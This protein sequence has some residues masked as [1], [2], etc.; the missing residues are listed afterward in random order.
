MLRRA[1]LIMISMAMLWPVPAQAM[2]KKDDKAV[3]TFHIETEAADNPKMIFQQEISGTT[4]Y[5]RRI[6]EIST[7]DLAVFT[8]FPSEDGNY[9]VV[10]RLK[11]RAVNRLTAI[12]GAN[13]GRWILASMNGRPVDAVMIDSQINDGVLVVWRGIN[14]VDVQTL[15][16]TMPRAGEEGRKKKR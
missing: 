14:L 3:V 6:P 15:D 10:F 2:G 8:A 1:L 13:Q 5:F 7:K 16:A 11:P 9:G 4:R 12:T